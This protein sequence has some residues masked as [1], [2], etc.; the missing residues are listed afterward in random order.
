MASIASIALIA[1]IASTTE[2]LG[3]L[4]FSVALVDDEM[5]RPQHA[6]TVGLLLLL[7]LVKDK[8]D[9]VVRYS[10]GAHQTPM[11]VASYDLLPPAIRAALPSEA[12]LASALQTET[13][14]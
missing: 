8:N 14:Q 12:D 7:L 2:Y 5:R 10:L 11:G 13:R 9:A 3:Q 6:D 4:G 1:L